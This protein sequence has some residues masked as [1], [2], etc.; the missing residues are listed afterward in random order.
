MSRIDV[1]TLVMAFE[2]RIEALEKNPPDKVPLSVIINLLEK[3]IEDELKNHFIILIKKELEKNIQ[4]EFKKMKVT[5]VKKTIKNVLSDNEFRIELENK[6]T[7]RIINSIR[8]F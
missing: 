3:A 5:F 2:K 7:K 4:E 6:L 8:E 1:Q